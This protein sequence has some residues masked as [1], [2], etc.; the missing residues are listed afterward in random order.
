MRFKVISGSHFQGG[1]LFSVGEEFDNPH[2]VDR[3]FPDRYE[4]IGSAPEPVQVENIKPTVAP[5]AVDLSTLKNVTHLFP[6]DE[7]DQVVITKEGYK[8]TIRDLQ[9]LPLHEVPV[10]KNE[11]IPLLQSLIG[12]DDEDEG[13]AE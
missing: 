2:R 8:Y 3:A 11:V 7:R 5:V 12:T 10:K 9:G 1:K 4:L 6:I 13:E